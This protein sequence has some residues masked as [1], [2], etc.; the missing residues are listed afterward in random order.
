MYGTKNAEVSADHLK[1]MKNVATTISK[2]LVSN[3]NNAEKKNMNNHHNGNFENTENKATT[4]QATSFISTESDT[5]ELFTGK[6]KTN[7]FNVVKDHVD[8]ENNVIRKRTYVCQHGRYYESNS[9]K[10]TGTKKM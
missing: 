4:S 1:N 8:R 5:S 7:G 10:E 2:H 9:N 3:I 6:R